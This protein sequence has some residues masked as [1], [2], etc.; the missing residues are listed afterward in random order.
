MRVTISLSLHQISVEGTTDP[1]CAVQGDAGAA[2]T[3]YQLDINHALCG[4]TLMKDSVRTYILVQ[5][6][7]PILTH[8][9]RRFMV[10][11]HYVP[12]AFT[13]SAGSVL[14]Y[15]QADFPKS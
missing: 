15:L 10:V 6:N 14:P 1:R 8:S 9:T 7:L 2:A 12:E 13:V 11:C 5:E 3:N 4:S